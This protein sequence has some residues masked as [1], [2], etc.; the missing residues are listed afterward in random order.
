VE[1]SPDRERK[2]QDSNEEENDRTKKVWLFVV[3]ICST[4]D[5]AKG[6]IYT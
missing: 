2:K 3:Q 6:N 4:S 1:E 5:S